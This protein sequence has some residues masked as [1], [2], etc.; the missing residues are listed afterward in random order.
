MITPAERTY[1][2]EHAYL[3]EHITP[4]VNAISQAEPFLVK[5]FL[6]YVKKGHLIF[7]GYPLREALN[8]SR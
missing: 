4:Y 5:D 1:I 8:E 2:E 6:V 3:P 7:V